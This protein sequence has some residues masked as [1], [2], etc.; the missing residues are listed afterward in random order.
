M[1]FEHLNSLDS[2][3]ILKEL[4]SEPSKSVA[5]TALSK[6]KIPDKKT[7]KY[8]YF[9]ITPIVSKDWD[10]LETKESSPKSTGNKIVLQDGAVINSGDIE[11]VSVEIKA[12]S[13]I[14]PTHFDALYYLSHLMA[15]KA[16]VIHCGKDCSFEIEHIFSTKEHLI[17]YRVVLVV[18][19][20]VHAQVYESFMGEAVDSLVL[21]GY[22]IFV[23]RDASLHLIKSHT[24]NDA[25]YTPIFTS[26]Y[27]VDENATMKL[28][29]FDFS[30]AKGLNIFKAYLEKD[31]AF[32]AAHLLYVDNSAKYG[33]VSEIEHQG[34]SSHSNQKAKS[35]LDNSAKGIFD[36]LIRVNNSAKWTKAHQ[37]SK[38]ILLHSGAYM[39]S[40]PQLEIY[41][42][43]LE[44][45]HGS[46]TG[47]LDERQLFYLRSRGIN[48]EDAR[49]ML[50]LAFA[51]EIVSTVEDK[52]LAGRIYVEFE[53]VYYGNYELECIK[54]CDGC[55]ELV[56]GESSEDD[57]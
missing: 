45:S 4:G 55:E 27:R 26:R 2:E 7:E 52:E 50:I 44:A 14:D 25:H 6:L 11:G 32:D 57:R 51:N 53:R 30:F 17:N 16:I 21:S 56:L 34:R 35:I 23:E 3:T 15:K 18:E 33:I 39:T 49:K 31:A 54:T 38:A 43:D 47:Q 40:K 41:I 28:S 24:L 46:T 10:I 5:A 19:P 20:N 29:S 9:D 8:R 37:N 48:E 22:D 36:A 1:R 13:E 42:D 12:F